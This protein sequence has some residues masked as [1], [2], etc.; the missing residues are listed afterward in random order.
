MYKIIG[1]DGKEYGPVTLQE[2]RDWLAQRRI[3]GQ[4]RVRAEN[5]PEWRPAAEIPELASLFAPTPEPSAGP[6]NP[7]VITPPAAPR[8]RKGL[9]VFS[10]VLG[11][12]SFVLCLNAITGIP[13][14]ICGH[15]ARRRAIRLPAQ[16]GGAGLATVGLV[17]GYL[18]LVVSMIILAMLLPA[19]SRPKFGTP[20]FG[21]VV[22][23]RTDCQRNLRELGLAF[24]VWALDHN[25]KYPFNVSTNSGGTLELRSLGNDGFDQNALVHFLAIS[26]ELTTP[27][28]LV[29]PKDRAKHAAG[30]FAELSPANITYQLRTGTNVNT[31]NPQE[32]LAVC[33]VDGNVLY[34]DGNVRAEPRPH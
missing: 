4:T 16:Y 21:T 10:F 32:V 5:N 8:P 3:N 18:S 19:V 15:I 9:A 31:G 24:K 27:F 28:L 23:D 25:D 12:C 6:G 29:C 2:L 34:C 17:L 22:P 14:I 20:R 11:L 13:G 1:A 30:G 33:P 7:P 26:N